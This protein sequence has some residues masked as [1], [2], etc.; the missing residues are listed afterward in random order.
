MEIKINTHGN[1]MPEFRDNGDWVDLCASKTVEMKAGEFCIIPLGISMQLPAGCEAH[2]LPRS[3]T[4]KKWGITMVNSMGIIDNSYCGD[5]DI[6][7]FAA[8]ADRD[9]KIEKG[10]RIAQFRIMKKQENFTFVPVETLGN[11][12]R[13]G[14]GSTGTR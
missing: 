3:S 1:P 6:W 12:D 8:R 10:D 4:Y 13:S 7:G 2:L 9:T 5:N 14:F 11:K